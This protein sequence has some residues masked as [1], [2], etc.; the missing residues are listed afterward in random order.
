MIERRNFDP[1]KAKAAPCSGLPPLKAP[2][3]PAK[4]RPVLPLVSKAAPPPR[5]TSVYKAHPVLP[6][7]S[8]APPSKA[9]AVV[10]SDDEQR[11]PKR[12]HKRPPVVLLS[13][14]K[15]KGKGPST[16]KRNPRYCRWCHVYAYITKGYCAN[17]ACPGPK[18]KGKGKCSKG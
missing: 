15:A 12:G 1:S 16:C 4:A 5:P 13:R 3:P 8:K 18:N 17:I 14:A 6:L 10:I 2:P 11:P 7:L 9:P